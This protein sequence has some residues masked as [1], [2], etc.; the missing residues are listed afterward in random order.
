MSALPAMPRPPRVPGRPSLQRLPA[1]APRPPRA[2]PV[3]QES[4][5]PYPEDLGAYPGT[6]ELEHIVSWWLI[7]RQ[8]YRQNRDFLFQV[9]I[10]TSGAIGGA[11]NTKG[12]LRCDFLLLP[13]GKH[14]GLGYPYDRGLIL[15]PFPLMG[16]GSFQIHTVNK[17]RLERSVLAT[18]HFRVVY[19]QDTDLTN[20]TDYVMREALR[21]VDIS[22]HRA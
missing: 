2:R 20:R 14:G 22:S 19:L 13:E 10:S 16:S 6:S 5:R 7:T 4:L 11:T 9:A 12:F 1:S 17:D 8:G 3:T 21:G 18:L 15:N